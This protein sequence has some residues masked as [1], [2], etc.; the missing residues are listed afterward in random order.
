MIRQKAGRQPQPNAAVIDSQSVKTAEEAEAETCGFDAGKQVK[1][2]K[3]H[4]L[5]GT[6]GLVIKV[7]VLNASIQDRDGAQMLFSHVRQ[8]LS[9]LQKVWAD[10]VYSGPQLGDWVKK[11]VIGC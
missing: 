5:V 8:V 1:G 2:H 10:V 6:L 4:L 11:N 3:R 7:I 9:R